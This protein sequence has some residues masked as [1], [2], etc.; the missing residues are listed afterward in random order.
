MAPPVQFFFFFSFIIKMNVLIFQ[1]FHLIDNEKQAF[2]LLF[3][4]LF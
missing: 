3:I 4:Y 1:L 2:I